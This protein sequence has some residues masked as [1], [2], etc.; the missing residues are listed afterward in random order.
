[1]ALKP[2]V[3]ENDHVQGNEDA[4]VELVEYGDYE[5][6]H[7]GRA[8]PII[9][10]IQEKMGDKLKFVFRNFPLA[11]IHPN[12]ITAAIATEAAALQGK[13]WEM[14]DIVFEH[15]KSLSVE[16]LLD[17]AAELGLDMHRFSKDFS[18]K[19]SLAKVEED[20]ESGIRSG[21]NGTPSF[22]INGNKYEGDWSEEMLLEVLVE[23]TK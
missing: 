16:R 13:F 2:A 8:Y 15:Q 10:N 23:K 14:H 12:A 1:M 21:V 6:P 7:C 3:G 4:S 22:F 18:D 5:C 20:F 19:Q 11:E 9:K 17:Y